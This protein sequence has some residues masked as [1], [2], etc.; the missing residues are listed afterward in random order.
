ML[1]SPV[2]LFA[3]S[4]VASTTI[5]ASGLAGGIDIV[6]VGDGPI[7]GPCASGLTLEAMSEVELCPWG[8]YTAVSVW[9]GQVS[10]WASSNKLT[11]HS[12]ILCHMP[13][14]ATSKAKA[15]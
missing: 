2:I 14:H 8:S 1:I 13:C 12:T 5:S 7:I 11:C 9:D 3:L 6:R 15:E 4:G 10:A